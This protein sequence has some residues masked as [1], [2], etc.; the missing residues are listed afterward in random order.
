MSAAEGYALPDMRVTFRTTSGTFVL[1][2]RLFEDGAEHELAYRFATSMPE[3][4]QSAGRTVDREGNVTVRWRKIRV[5]RL[6]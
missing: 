1:P 4:A 3:G 6:I 5:V 2:A